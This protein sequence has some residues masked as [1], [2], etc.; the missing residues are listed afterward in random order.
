MVVNSSTAHFEKYEYS[1]A[2]IEIEN[3]FWEVF[4][5]DYLEIVKKRVYQGEGD[6]KLSAQYTLY[7]SL[8]TVLKMFA[9]I[10]PF[11]TE[12]LYQEHFRKNENVKSIHQMEWPTDS[13]VSSSGAATWTLFKV[14][15]SIISKVRKE[16]TS[17]Q[18]SMNAEIVLTITKEDKLKIKELLEDLKNVTNAREVKEGKF[19]VEFVE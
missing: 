17:A 1:R 2:K 19:K 13:E 15:T 9:P 4:C 3:F 7:H 16:K 11:V 18:K 8:L 6:E 14:I 10:V 5:N 12:H